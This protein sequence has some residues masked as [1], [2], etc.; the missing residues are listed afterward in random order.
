MKK[1]FKVMFLVI[2]ALIICSFNTSHDETIK[3]LIN[4]VFE[5]NRL[6]NL[7]NDVTSADY[8]SSS[9]KLTNSLNF[10]HKFYKLWNEKLNN[11][12]TLYNQKLI[13]DRIEKTDDFYKVFFRR[14]LELQSSN[15]SSVIQ[16]SYDE[17]YIA[18]LTLKNNHPLIECIVFQEETP[19][20]YKDLANVTGNYR[21]LDTSDYITD[22][23]DKFEHI[24]ILLENFKSTFDQNNNNITNDHDS[25]FYNRYF[26]NTAAVAYAQKY[27]LNYNP[28]YRDFTDQ[29]G[30]C[31][32]FV[33]QCLHA[34]G[35]NLSSAWKPYTN[36][37][38]S[39]HPLR[40]YLIN[41]NLAE[42]YDKVSPNPAGSVIQFFSPQKNWWTHSGVITYKGQN[43]CLYCCHTYNKLNYPLSGVY[44]TIYHKIRSLEI[45]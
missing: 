43:D 6:S 11:K 33:S 45:K 20:G 44:P 37:W 8:L 9:I 40:N 18:L 39:V 35:L 15:F 21:N 29:G 3:K 28:E 41:N 12:I 30:D 22:W 14:N 5:L 27:A 25:R 38:Y 23:K 10:K 19:E 42:E 4:E 34:G 32:N 13:F 26:S 1:F 7:G 2:S 24:D 16:K 36:A 17:K 31:T